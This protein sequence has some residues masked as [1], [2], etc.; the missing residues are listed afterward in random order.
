M[1]EDWNTVPAWP[2]GARCAV[3]LSFDVDGPTLWADDPH[4]LYDSPK[5]FAIGAYGPARGTRRILDLLDDHR[6]PAT[7][8]VPGWVAEWWPDTIRE[9][10][11]RDHELGHHG[12]MHELYYSKSVEEQRELILRSQDAFDKVAGRTA[13]GFRTPSGDF[14]ADSPRLLREL[15]FSYS[16]S[17]RGDDRPY[18]WIIDGEPTDLIE[19]P[20]QWEL[21]DYPQFSYNDA[22]PVPS[23]Q[24]RLAGTEATLDNWRR[25]FDG[26]HRYGLCYVLMAHPQ[27]MGRPSRVRLLERLIEHIKGH[28]DVWFATGAQIAEW[29]R[30]NR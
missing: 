26:Y 11:E 25:E 18:R 17:M 5:R 21:D 6:I 27:V 3:M 24:D 4:E 29:W 9:I 22:P 10:A 15:G 2:G 20:A 14:R 23:G 1:I 28:D 8:F 13:T 7:F 30:D 12:Y 19:I 16:S